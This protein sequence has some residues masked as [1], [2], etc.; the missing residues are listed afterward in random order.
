[1]SV[2]G[3]RGRAARERRE[4]VL[5]AAI[6]VFAERGFHRTTIRDIARAAGVAD[7]T[8]YLYFEHK[9]ALLLGIL[10]RLNESD[11]REVD[12]AQVATIGFRPFVRQYFAHRWAMFDDE[13][14][15]ALRV[16]LSE[17]LVDADLRALYLDRV[18]L[19]TLALAEPLFRARVEAGEMRPLDLPL[20]LRAVAATFLGL[21]VMRLLG[22][23]HLR[24]HWD[25][26]PDL[27]TTML[28][29]GIAPPIGGAQ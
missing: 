6:A 8:I 3:A 15:N 25:A 9:T 27:L 11:R 24:H 1:M 12:L 22:D 5:D 16:V 29:D 21:I 2:E 17:V 26:V 10:D 4:R 14:L 13:G 23:E 7:G 18:V 28:L 19:P 20:T